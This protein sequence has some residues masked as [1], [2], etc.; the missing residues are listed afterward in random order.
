[1][2][3]YII[4]FFAILPAWLLAQEPVELPQQAVPVDYS[5]VQSGDPSGLLEIANQHYMS[6]EYEKAVLIY[7]Q[8]LLSGRESAQLYF[9]L[10]NAYFKS[11]N[12]PKAILNYERAKLLEPANEDI[13]FNIRVANQFTVDNV[14]ALPQPFFLRWRTTVVN[15][16]S[17]DTWAKISIAS[18][19]M[20]LVLLA[21]FLFS[22]FAW[23]KRLTFWSGF[24]FLLLSAFGFS[25]ANR[26][27]K[28]LEER[29]HA[30][31]FCP[32]VAVKSSPSATGTDLFL[33][34]EGLKIEITD[35]L[36]SWKEIRIPDGNKGWMPD[37]CAVR[38]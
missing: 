1:M 35:S 33:I 14:L 22:G 12:I 31:V 7:E 20:F 17:S 15:M 30:I 3:R 19:L 5:Q 32:R 26:Q 36:N 27:K 10:G 8:I 6:Q 34:H 4:I 11:N 29:N 18:F 13:D 2:K 24:I 28:A 16:A 37:S 23:V 21:V 9:N 38:I 25:F